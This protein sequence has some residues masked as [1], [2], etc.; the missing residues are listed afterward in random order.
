MYLGRPKGAVE[1]ETKLL[2]KGRITLPKR[3]REA[4]GLKE[5][6]S[7]IIEVTGNQVLIKPKRATTVAK[8]RGII[9]TTVRIEEIEEAP[10]KEDALH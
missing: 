1:I 9:K 6:D 10:G 5:R 3:V 2:D 8:T 7:V 4:L